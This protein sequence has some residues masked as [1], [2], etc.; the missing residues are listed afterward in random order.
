[1]HRIQIDRLTATVPPAIDPPQ[2][3]R[4]QTYVETARRCELR[5]QR[6]RKE[7]DQALQDADAG[8]A[9]ADGDPSE[10]NAILRLACELDTLERV[11]ARV[12]GW[13]K[14]YVAAL[15]SQHTAEAY[16]EAEVYGDG[17]PV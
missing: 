2:R 7:L 14:E 11:Q 13:L 17:G 3:T 8:V 1:M 16:S 9:P 4:L 5:I 10:P 6:L 12:D 15:V